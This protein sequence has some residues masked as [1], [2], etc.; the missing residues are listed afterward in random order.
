MLHE[1]QGN[2]HVGSQSHRPGS[3]CYF[4]LTM[5]LLTLRFTLYDKCRGKKVYW[6]QDY[7]FLGKHL[8]QAIPVFPGVQGN[9]TK[10]SVFRGSWLGRSDMC[11]C[12]VE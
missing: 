9:T 3:A 2:A 11:T 6:L 1:F 5:L 7:Q 4:T 10:G 8:V 12:S